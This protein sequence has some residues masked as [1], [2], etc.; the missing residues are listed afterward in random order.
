[1]RRIGARA[2]PQY[3]VMV[4]GG[5]TGHEAT[6][7]RLAAKVP[8]RR[9][10]E[11]I[12]RLIALYAREHTEDESAS[13]FFVRIDVARVKKELADLERL[14]QEDSLPA[15]FVDLGEVS[16]FNPLVMDGECSA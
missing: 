1:M 6:F 16:E 13:D 2:V 10:P 4:G 3:F 9:I 12:E 8:A 5:A 14:T 11:V 15:D 7:A